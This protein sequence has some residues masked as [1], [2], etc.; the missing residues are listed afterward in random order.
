[1]GARTLC[2]A[3]KRFG[4]YGK[5]GPESGLSFEEST[6][7]ARS[8]VFEALEVCWTEVHAGRMASQANSLGC[9]AV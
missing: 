5:G 6:T 3:Q 1:M 8:E 7:T 9:R 2:R 4:A